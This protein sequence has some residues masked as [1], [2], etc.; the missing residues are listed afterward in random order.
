VPGAERVAVVTARGMS[1]GAEVG[2]VAVRVAEL[3]L[4]VSGVGFVRALK[5][6]QVGA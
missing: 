1:P 3:V 2:E 4:V 5:L 6:P